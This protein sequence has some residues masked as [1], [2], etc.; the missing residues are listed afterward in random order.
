M[1]FILPKAHHSSDSIIA[2]NFFTPCVL[3]VDA[4]GRTFRQLWRTTSGSKIRNL[5][6]HKL[7]FVFDNLL[8]VD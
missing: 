1:G 6:D 8:D 7:L 2:A 5:G 4:V 3:S